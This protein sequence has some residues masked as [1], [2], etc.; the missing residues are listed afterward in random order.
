MKDILHFSH[1]NGFPGGS[2]RKMLSSLQADYNVQVIDRLAHNP[3]Y[4]V[5]DNWAH[6]CDEL[7][8]FFEREYQQPVI[9]A[10]HS[11]G[12]LLSLMVA[13]RRPDL[14][15]AIIMLDSPALTRL[16]ANGLRL[17]KWLG[18]VDRIT[19]GGRSDGRRA[20]WADR[21]EAFE[22]FRGKTLMK[23]FDP[24]CLRDYVEAGTEPCEEGVRLRFDPATELQIYRTIP[25]NIRAVQPLS[26]PGLAIGGSES[27]VYR[28]VN[29][30]LMHSRLGM[31]VRWLPGSHMFPLEYP[32]K[33]AG[34]I[35]QWLETYL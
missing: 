11:L 7:I 28:R 19:P 29:G 25:H 3:V 10:G 22:Y 35:R 16:Q 20:V 15:K 4:P 30:A 24:D 17:A 27:K 6:L 33:T 32:E 8:H 34:L 23:R 12:G 21:N 2:Y 5:T 9:A 13:Q 1:A 26:V 14:V 31:T 18:M